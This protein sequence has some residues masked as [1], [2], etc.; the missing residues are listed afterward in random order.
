MMPVLDMKS[1]PLQGIKL[2][3]S[4]TI[5]SAQALAKLLVPYL[6]KKRV[7][8]KII[9]DLLNLAY[10]N[11]GL[12]GFSQIGKFITVYPRNLEE[13]CAVADELTRLTRDFQGPEIPS[14]FPVTPDGIIY[15]RYG[16][17]HNEEPYIIS[18]DG[19]RFEDQRG[20]NPIPDW[21]DNP[22]A[23][24]S[25]VK[26]LPNR[27][28][29]YDVLRSRGKG[30]VYRALDVGN[31]SADKVIIKE[32]RS[33]GEVDTSGEDALVR[34]MWEERVLKQLEK[35]TPEIVPRIIDLFETKTRRFLVLSD[36][37]EVSLKTL[38]K[39]HEIDYSRAVTIALG[40]VRSVSKIHS[41]GIVL[42]D[43]SPDN[44]ILKK[45][46]DG[47]ILID[48]EYAWETLRG[49]IAPVGTVGFAPPECMGSGNRVGFHV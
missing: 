39:E 10:L 26:A 4:G 25:P 44:V 24:P 37:G 11:R 49:K 41:Q 27:Y 46:N 22:F 1:I 31:C 40:L 32:Y 15:Y 45:Q 17:F 36:V 8:F 35:H 6:I 33:Y 16:A 38:I 9:G 47:V 13:C 18:P 5:V 14:D 3:V 21:A 20:K 28:I 30:A 43:L 29:V 23:V 48:F 19:Q 12:Y 7:A 2:H 42:C 34:C